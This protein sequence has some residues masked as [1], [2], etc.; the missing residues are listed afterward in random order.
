LPR[1][2]H[3]TKEHL[4]R[5][6]LQPERQPGIAKSTLSYRSLTFANIVNIRKHRAI[7]KYRAIAGQLR[8]HTSWAQRRATLLRACSSSFVQYLLLFTVLP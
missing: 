2:E 1:K 7:R 4:P 6:D 3:L 8:M 5:S